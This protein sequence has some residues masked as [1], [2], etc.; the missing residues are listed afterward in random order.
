MAPT[1]RKPENS[2]FSLD[3]FINKLSSYGE[4][5]IIDGNHDYIPHNDNSSSSIIII[6]EK[7]YI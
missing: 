5:I 1:I 4:I 6:F 7:L 2:G 3:R